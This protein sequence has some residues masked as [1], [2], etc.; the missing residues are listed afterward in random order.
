MENN[1]KCGYRNCGCQIGDGVRSD[2]KYCSLSCRDKE[3]TYIKRENRRV[4]K[5]RELVAKILKECQMEV[6]VDHNI[7]ELYEKIYGKNK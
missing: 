1:R 3:R 2:S 6:K 7:L 4:K 5:E